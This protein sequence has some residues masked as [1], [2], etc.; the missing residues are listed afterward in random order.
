MS[1]LHEEVSNHALIS[2]L[3]S[4]SAFFIFIW[5]ATKR[6][7]ERASEAV[8]SSRMDTRSFIWTLDWGTSGRLCANV[9]SFFP[10]RD[11]SAPHQGLNTFL[12]YV[13]PDRNAGKPGTEPA[14]SW[15]VI[16]PL[17][18][19]TNPT[20]RATF[21]VPGAVM[22][23][24]RRRRP[25]ETPHPSAGEATPD[26]RTP[27]SRVGMRV[28][29]GLEEVVRCAPRHHGFAGPRARVKLQT[30]GSMG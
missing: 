7:A 5:S 3:Q 9:L 4:T 27:T 28:R 29:W 24:A 25:F 12:L 19:E 26:A 10:W 20:N 14:A 1:L 17:I 23:K 16:Q 13:I 21:F 11:I 30:E 15:A 8:P 22:Q 2:S 18:L 6:L